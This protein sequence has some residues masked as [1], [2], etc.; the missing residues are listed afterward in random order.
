M[1]EK[2]QILEILVEASAYNLQIE[3]EE[4]AKKFIEDGSA[5]NVVEAYEMAFNEWVK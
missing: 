2:Q 5:T 4:W 3:V 1:E